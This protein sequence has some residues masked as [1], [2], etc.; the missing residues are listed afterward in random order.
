VVGALGLLKP[1]TGEDSPVPHGALCVCV[2]GG[3]GGGARRG[4]GARV[5][6]PHD[7]PMIRANLNGMRDVGIEA[8]L[9]FL[10]PL[11]RTKPPM[12]GSCFSGW[13]RRLSALVARTRQ[14]LAAPTPL[15]TRPGRTGPAG[16]RAGAAGCPTGQIG[17]LVV[18][19]VLNES[20]RTCLF[21]GSK[22]VVA[23]P[24]FPP[25]TWRR[26]HVG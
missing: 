18:L 1:N 9:I 14:V 20:K 6:K 7:S 16:G 12:R 19:M 13:S 22:P 11:Y 25:L 8:L 15:S 17:G 23:I 10:S 4:R 26:S 21:G 5:L 2:R 24:R 3:G